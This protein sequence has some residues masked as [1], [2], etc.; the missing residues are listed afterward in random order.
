MAR[1]N[2]YIPEEVKIKIREH[3]SE[4]YKLSLDGYFSANE[5]EDTLTGDLGATLR[6]KN[7]KVFVRNSI[8]EIPGEW[9]WGIDYHKFRGRGPGATENKLGADG[10]FE[11]TLEL[12]R[13]VE[14]KH[15]C[16]NQK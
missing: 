8:A 13:R 9:T 1:R 6:I 12:G 7:Q 14:K 5:E 3:I 11:L 15:L 10:L 4:K 16:F 2:L